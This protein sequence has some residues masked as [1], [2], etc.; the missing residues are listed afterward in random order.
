VYPGCS[1]KA[2]DEEADQ[3]VIKLIAAKTKELVANV[4]TLKVQGFRTR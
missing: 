2:A 3:A 1:L 4:A